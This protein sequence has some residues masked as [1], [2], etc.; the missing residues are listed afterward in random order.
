MAEEE[1]KTKAQRRAEA[2][3]E[4]KRKEQE[5]ARAQK[6]ASIRNAVI[7]VAVVAVV[8]LVSVPA[9]SN[10]F[11]GE[12]GGV[13]VPQAQ[14]LEARESA[15][16]EMVVENETFGEPTHLD[17]ET[18]PPA[19]ALYANAPVR[20]TVSGPHF[21]NQSR[22]I[23][24]IPNQPL[25]ERQVTP[26]L[27]HGALVVWYDPAQVDE[28]TVADMEEWMQD[29][30]DMGYQSRAGGS[31]FVSPYD[32]DIS[33][34]IAMRMWGFALD[35]Q[36]WDSTAA[37]SML[38]DYYGTHGFAPEANLSPYPE[39]ALT[40]GTGEDTGTEAPSDTAEEPT[41]ATTEG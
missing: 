28:A 24:G 2:R 25:D 5:A 10:L 40:Y 32:G 7:A 18:A 23:S 30:L 3:A 8:A 1:R 41:D 15:G 34:P 17:P 39:G 22:T 38:I 31:I 14:A 27:E 29:R 6:Q 26:N 4:R 11:G 21:A 13:V 33:A 16:C 37:D 12:E 19:D 35:C 9:L 36:E 20:P